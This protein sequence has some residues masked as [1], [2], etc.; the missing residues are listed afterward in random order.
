MS[1][2]KLIAETVEL[3]EQKATQRIG[4]PKARVKELLAEGFSPLDAMHKAEDEAFWNDVKRAGPSERARLFAK[5]RNMSPEDRQA[6]W[7]AHN[8]YQQRKM[9]GSWQ[10]PEFWSN[11][12]DADA[13]RIA[14]DL[15]AEAAAS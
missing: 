11:L 10:D 1:K 3:A 2:E 5:F 4:G 14:S 6:N 13:E 15:A 7:D 12:S 8:T 9:R